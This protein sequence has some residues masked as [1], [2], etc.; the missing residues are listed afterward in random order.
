MIE[1]YEALKQLE[2]HIGDVLH[3]LLQ[4][5]QKMPE[6]SDAERTKKLS[7]YCEILSIQLSIWN[8]VADYQE[9]TVSALK[10]VG[11]D[12][13]DIQPG[14]TTSTIAELDRLAGSPVR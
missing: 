6:Y 7:A 4:G 13:Q 9:E 1:D 3:D 12:I 10:H 14:P 11:A 2:T 8:L 5:V